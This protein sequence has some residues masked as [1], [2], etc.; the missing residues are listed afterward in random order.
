VRLAL[1]PV[2]LAGREPLL[3]E[4]DTRLSSSPERAGP[5]MVVL[6]GLGG[7]GKTSVA[8]EY[9]YRQLGGAGVC[10]QFAAEEPAVLAAQ[11]AVLA[12]QLGTRD[13]ADGRDPVAA[14][15]AVLARTPAK[16]LVIFDNAPELAAVQPFLPPAGLGRVLVTSQSQHW[17]AGWTVRVPVLDSKVAAEFLT[18]RAGGGDQPAALELAAELGGLPLA[19]EQAAAYMQASGITLARYLTLFR[20]R[21]ADLLAR[22]EAAG[23]QEHAAA[24]LG[25]AL[26]RLGHDAPAAAGLLRLLAFLAPEPVPLGLLLAGLDVTD[27]LVTRAGEMPVSLPGDALALADAIAALR[28]YSLAALAEDGLIQVHRLVQA[29]TRAHLTA[30]TA[31]QWTHTATVLV[32]RAIPADTRLPTAWA[33]CAVLLPH[34]EHAFLDA[35]PGMARMADYLAYSGSYAAGRDL[36][37]RIAD[38][39]ERT[40]GPEHPDT[41][42]ARYGVARWTGSAGEPSMARDQ[43]AALTA[44]TRDCPQTAR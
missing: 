24:T 7:V 36:W 28:R 17:P 5:R 4:I 39:R 30:G 20:A 21:Q 32:E 26:T 23:H 14:V 16:W 11:F 13:L 18:A 27:L 9:A 1:R 44:V 6:C 43:F 40:L 37:R 3:A 42:G 19:L 35:S 22:G 15:H 12:A 25:L 2:F 29:V 38:A 10:W 8:V 33:V 34:A 31:D 41:L